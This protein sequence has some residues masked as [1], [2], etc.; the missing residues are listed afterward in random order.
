MYDA[1][2]IEA[3]T[4]DPDALTEADT[5]A[6]L[7][8]QN[9]ERLLTDANGQ[10]HRD[11]SDLAWRMD[12]ITIDHRLRQLANQRPQLNGEHLIQPVS[13]PSNE[14]CLAPDPLLDTLLEAYT[15]LVWQFEL[16]EIGQ[17]YRPSPY[18]KRFLQAFS[19]QPYLYQASFDHLPTLSRSEAEALVVDLNERLSA[20]YCRLSQPDFLH[21]RRRNQRNSRNNY[22]R[23]WQFFN[24]LSAHYS[25]LQI[26]RVDCEYT[27]ESRPYVTYD[28]AY[29][30]REKLLRQV[31][32]HFPSLAGYL[33]KLEWGPS[34]GFHYHFIFCFDG[35][36]VRQDISVGE[37]IGKRW[38]CGITQ[39]AG[40]YFNCN[41]GA[42]DRYVHNAL[43]EFNYYDEVK[44]QG[45]DYLATYLTKVDEQVVMITP[46]RIFQTSQVPEPPTG[47]RPGRPRQYDLAG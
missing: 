46:H 25:R 21:E 4:V 10:Q 17:Q 16:S 27:A 29:T 41:R 33:W 20:W 11:K 14:V 43:G 18:A 23:F 13:Y 24:A 12:L 45:L 15:V 5:R 8:E 7:A 34:T 35:H 42:S 9:T 2:L 44:R 3:D 26:V 39:G 32:D 31:R 28:T 19:S 22:A 38:A 37:Q 36:Q 40:R 1:L 6:I 30:H 47:P